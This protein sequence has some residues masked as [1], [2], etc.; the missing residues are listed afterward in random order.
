[1][2]ELRRAGRR[3]PPGGAGAAQPG[4]AAACTD[5]L[6]VPGPWHDRLP[7]FRLAC[8]PSSGDELQSEYLLPRARALDALDA[9]QRTAGRLAPVTQ[10]CEIP[11]IAADGLW[12]SPSYRRDS[13]AFHFT[14]I[15]DWPA[16]APVLARV[17]ECL[18]PLRARPHRGKL[19]GTTPRL[20]AAVTSDWTTSGT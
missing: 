7:H 1:M 17:E 15:K 14:W 5:Q 20:C 16:V 11:T 10:V 19:F 12:L 13:V 18:A 9:L 6:G 4:V 3:T 8:T 2:P